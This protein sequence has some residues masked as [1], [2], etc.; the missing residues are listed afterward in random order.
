MIEMTTMRVVF[1][2]GVVTMSACSSEPALPD[3][4]SASASLDGGGD[5]ASSGAVSADDADD[6][7]DD[8]GTG[9]LD[10]AGDTSMDDDAADTGSFIPA[11]DAGGV[12]AC[13]IWEQDCPEGEK[14]MP[15]ASGTSSW[16]ATRC[17]PVDANAKEVGDTC[18]VV[19]SDAS[20]QDDCVL[21]AMCF[22]VDVDSGEGVCFAMCEGSEAS[23]TC[24]D[25]G[26]TCSISNDGVL[27][28]CLPLCNPILQDCPI[29]GVALGCYSWQGME[30]F[31]C[32]PDYSFD[33]GAFGDECEYFNYCDVGLFCSNPES[34]PGCTGA[35]CCNEYCDTAAATQCSGAAQG[36]ECI[37]WFA[38]G[39]EPPG[40]E[41]V[42]YCGIP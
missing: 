18:T 11:P 2:V 29:A 42:G 12:V 6:D 3:F 31:V 7:D 40:F 38:E 27:A 32:W 37:A 24:S 4:G 21:G 23:A 36:Q 39:T 16:D 17:S 25:A 15:Y 22:A 41:D 20:G 28:L 10:E 14:C 5:E 34:V 8:D 33:V 19:G 35:S 30:E 9:A 13:D 26:D 1:C